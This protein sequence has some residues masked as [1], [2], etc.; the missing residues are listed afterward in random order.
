SPRPL[1]TR[2]SSDLRRS[3]RT[4]VLERGVVEPGTEI[5]SLLVREPVPGIPSVAKLRVLRGFEEWGHED[6][7]GTQ[8]GPVQRGETRRGGDRSHH[9][10]VRHIVRPAVDLL[11]TGGE[12]AEVLGR[13]GRVDDL[14]DRGSDHSRESLL[15]NLLVVLALDDVVA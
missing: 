15:E 14:R 13:R 1:P 5:C 11:V 10:L 6:L 2:R 7:V 8:E 12:P 4:V 3:T 9:G